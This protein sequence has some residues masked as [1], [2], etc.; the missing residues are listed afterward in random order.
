MRRSRP[1][2]TETERITTTTGDA[3]EID[4]RYSIAE[5]NI[6]VF[7]VKGRTLI[8]NERVVS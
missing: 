7:D 4:R 8:H 2:Q 5:M 6:L 1:T 3:R